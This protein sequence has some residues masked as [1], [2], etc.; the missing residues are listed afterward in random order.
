LGTLRRNP[1]V[2][3]RQTPQGLDELNVK[4]IAILSGAARLVKAGGRLV[5]ATCSLLDEENEAIV[6]QFLA[7]H[8]DFLV[9]PMKDVLA[10]QKI[11][12]DMQDYLKLTPPKHQTDGFFAAVLER[13]K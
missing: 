3:W 2:K 11:D 9:V 13:K 4:Q 5:Y 7:A 8:P 6:T 1:D 10:E 12:L